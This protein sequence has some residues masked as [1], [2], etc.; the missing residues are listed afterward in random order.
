LCSFEPRASER[1]PLSGSANTM[2]HPVS[3]S[4]PRR[5]QFRRPAGPKTGSKISR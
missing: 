4:S 3:A 1:I 5:C 2:P